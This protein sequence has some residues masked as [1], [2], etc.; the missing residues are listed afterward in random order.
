MSQARSE[1]SHSGVQPSL[2]AFSAR[3][4]SKRTIFLAFSYLRKTIKSVCL[5]D[6]A[7]YPNMNTHVHPHF[8]AVLLSFSQAEAIKWGTKTHTFL[9]N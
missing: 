7:C 8:D 9:K 3:R 1:M 2:N 4:Q 6:Q 5:N